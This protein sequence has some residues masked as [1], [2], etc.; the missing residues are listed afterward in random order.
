MSYT[1]EGL[2]FA[3]RIGIDAWVSELVDGSSDIRNSPV[4]LAYDNGGNP[5]ISY[6]AGKNEKQM[7]LKFAHWNVNSE[8]WD[9]EIVVDTREA[10]FVSLAYDPA[11]N[12]AIAYL[13]KTGH[14]IPSMVFFAKLA[15]W[16]GASSSWDIETVD[17]IYD[18]TLYVDLAFDPTAEYP[19]YPSIVYGKSVF[20]VHFAC[21]NGSS[22]DFE[23]VGS[24]MG[25]SL[26]YDS[27]GTAFV[28]YYDLYEDQLKVA[29]RYGANDWVPEIVDS[30]GIVGHTSIALDP[31]GN[32][33]VSYQDNASDAC[34]L[35][36]A[37]R[38]PFNARPTV[39][40][41]SPTDGATF[42]SGET[43][44]FLGTATDLE[45]WDLTA[46]LVWESDIQGDIGTPSAILIDGLHTITASVTDSGGKTGDASVI[47]TVGELPSLH[48]EG[49]AMNSGKAGPNYYALATVWVMDDVGDVEGATVYGQWSGAVSSDATGVTDADGKVTL[50]SPKKK[51]GG[52]FIFTITDVVLS[53]YIYSP[54][55]DDW[56]Q[57]TVP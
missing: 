30:V 13:D 31:A 41:I 24:G 32:P 8:S 21:Y 7:V 28:S 22:W 44:D 52:T 11:G 5:S 14:N 46:G 33:A 38:G 1:N 12:P 48:V 19:G 3:R 2:Y 45:D 23:A 29:Q 37:W 49:I 20:D 15:R 56:A 17:T 54:E 4:S 36:F 9:I 50:Q 39:T 16:N 6:C 35:K 55:P 10:R 47:I 27:G 40:I 57:I 25:P 53:G 34:A 51:K 43:I 18:I 42:D 26:V